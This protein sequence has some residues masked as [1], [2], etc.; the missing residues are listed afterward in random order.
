MNAFYLLLQKSNLFNA[1]NLD[2]YVNVLDQ[3]QNV[4]ILHFRYAAKLRKSESGE[5]LKPVP[6]PLGQPC[7]KMA[8]TNDLNFKP[9]PIHLFTLPCD[10]KPLR[11]ICSALR[12]RCHKCYQWTR[13]ERMFL[14][15]ITSSLTTEWTTISS[16]QLCSSKPALN[17]HQ[18]SLLED[19]TQTYKH[20]LLSCI[21]AYLHKISSFLCKSLWGSERDCG[22]EC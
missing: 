16:Y 21:V 8:P 17:A 2:K 3:C 6:Q 7:C 19:I 5:T 1:Y 12:E 14:F 11:L 22:T 9:S 13:R 15:S 4:R 20:S 10:S 18:K